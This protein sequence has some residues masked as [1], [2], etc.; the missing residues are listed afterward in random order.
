[1]KR[2]KLEFRYYF[3]AGLDKR[4]GVCD[5]EGSDVFEKDV[6][7]DIHYIG[8]IPWITPDDIA[9]M[10]DDEVEELLDENCIILNSL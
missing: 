7:G 4:T 1:M 3:N 8:S 5:E 2:E 6:L 10:D 9:E